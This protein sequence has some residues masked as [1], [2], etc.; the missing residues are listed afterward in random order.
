MVGI[1]RLIQEAEGPFSPVG[2]PIK[3]IT[4][5]ALVD[6]LPPSTT[7]DN[8]PASSESETVCEPN[9]DDMDRSNISS[10]DEQGS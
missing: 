3:P 10:S 5:N 8:P 6:A 4:L 7:C 9:I 1:K 2:S